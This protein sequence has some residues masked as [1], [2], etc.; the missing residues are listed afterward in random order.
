MNTPNVD[1]TGTADTGDGVALVYGVRAGTGGLGHS[2]ASAIT[3]I[4]RGPRQVT[5][6]GPGAS[7]PWSLGRELPDAHWI[8]LQP[9]VPNWLARYSPLRWRA[10][11][12]VYLRDRS[13]GKQ[14]ARIVGAA[15]P[16]A[17]YLF[18]QVALE[19]LQWARRSGVPTVLDNPNGHIRNFYDV[20]E[21]ESRKWHCGL[22]RGHPSQEMIDRVEEEY[23]LATYI[24]TYSQWG[25]T[26][27]T[28]YGISAEKVKVVQQTVNLDKFRPAAVRPPAD[29]PLRV[30]YVGSLDLRKGFI[31]LLQAM[32]MI[33]SKYVALHMV[34][35]TG[36]RDCARLFAGAAAGLQV[37]CAPGDPLPVYHES[38]VMVIP[39]LEDGLPFVLVEGMAAGL[40][41]VTTPEAGAAEC[42]RPG[43]SG[44]VVPSAQAEQIAA[45]LEDAMKRRRQLPEMGMLARADVEHYAGPARLEELSAWFCTVAPTPISAYVS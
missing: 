37:R 18:T 1:K 8:N 41:V 21:R 9:T 15:S 28:R 38:E 6:L 14:A 7:T 45:A 25:K 3:A 33:G 31:Y 23:E 39:T 4:T 29:G 32:K 30:C 44:W 20:Y 13:V 17:C 10:G 35:A 34:G 16:R 40:P 12:L 22:F 43:L 2:V 36:D 19:T 5:A 24:R 42:I 26:S 11:Q 27:M